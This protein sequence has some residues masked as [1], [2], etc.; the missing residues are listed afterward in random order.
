M[1][2]YLSKSD[3]LWQRF[4]GDCSKQETTHGW[5]NTRYR[6]QGEI[7]PADV[8]DTPSTE[9]PP[10]TTSTTT[11]DTATKEHI[12]RWVRNLL[13]TPLTEVQVSLLVHGPNLVV[14]PR[15]PPMGITTL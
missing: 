15:H 9:E 3:Q 10:A 12:N 7:L 5:P 1:K 6:E 4:R 8:T 11:T 13:S 2:R 14:A